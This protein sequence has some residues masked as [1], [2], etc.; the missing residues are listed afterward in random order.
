MLRVAACLVALY[1][2]LSVGLADNWPS[3]RGPH[4][5]GTADGKFP[6]EWSGQKNL[7]FK[8]A[9][10]AGGSSPIVWGDRIYVT[11]GK[12]SRNILTCLNMKGESQW[13]APIGEERKGKHQKA[14]GANSSPLTDGEI[15][16][17]YFKSGDIAATDM[18]GKVLWQK[19]LQKLFGEDTLW[20]DLGTSP[21]LTSKYVVIACMQTGPS[22][23]V[24]FDKKTG[25]VAWKV[26]RAVPAPEEAAQSYSTPIVVTHNGQ[27]Q[28]VVL[29]ADHVTG[30]DAS[31]GK[32]LWRV[33]DMNPDQNKY[34]RS[35]SSPVVEGDIVIAPYARGGSLTAVRLGGSGDVTKSHVLW[36]HFGDKAISADV[37]TPTAQAGKTYVATDKGKV[38]CL[39]VKTGE[40]IWSVELPKSRLA[41]SSS[42][43]LGGDHI[44]LTREDGTTFVLSAADG[45]L[46][47]TNALPENEKTVAT[48][49]LVNGK[50]LVRTFDHLYC[51]GE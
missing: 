18:T 50:V 17:A 47:A 10:P 12:D 15:V 4:L 19:N 48:P 8:I 5:N 13:E 42:P 45:K 35:I 24:A 22:Y 9:F 41:F 37:P 1:I 32:E 16:C 14:T 33:G 38:G 36:S 30:H 11:A 43:I 7:V 23:L 34:F 3:W 51:F 39:D 49:A 28:L 25:E 6:I 26:D 40:T 29:G 27:E 21:V 20:W 44:Y 46:A 31:N 2:C